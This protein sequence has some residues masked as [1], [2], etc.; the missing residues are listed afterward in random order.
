MLKVNQARFNRKQNLSSQ[1]IQ[2]ETF[3]QNKQSEIARI[4]TVWHTAH[5]IHT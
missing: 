4:A 2:L 3:K 1:I 5:D